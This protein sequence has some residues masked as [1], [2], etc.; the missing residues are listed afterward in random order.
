MP[1]DAE[2]KIFIGHPSAQKNYS[3][4]WVSLRFYDRALTE[5]E[6]KHNASVETAIVIPE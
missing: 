1:I 3:A 6:V 2:G 4:N 5:D